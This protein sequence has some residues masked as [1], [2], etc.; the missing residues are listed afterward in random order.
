M[1][2]R[3]IA[4]LAALLVCL[5]VTACNHDDNEAPEPDPAPLV[6]SLPPATFSIGG[7][8]SGSS[9]PLT[10]QNSNGATLVVAASGAF[11][12]A[13]QVA[14]GSAYTVTVA[15]PPTS[16]TCTVA[17]GSGSALANVTNIAVT[18]TNN[19][20]TIGGTVT[21]LGAGKSVTL[22]A[23]TDGMSGDLTLSA[24]GTYT[25]P[26][27]F[28]NN[29]EFL[30][31]VLAQPLNQT[32]TVD[33]EEGTVSNASV[34]NLTLTC[35][36]NSASA[37]NWGDAAAL[38]TD[39]DPQ[40]FDTFRTPKVAFDAAGNALA[41]WEQ[42]REIGT[43]SEIWSSRYTGGAWAAPIMIPNQGAPTPGTPSG[44]TR[45][46]PQLAVAA[47]G[48]AVAVWVENVYSVAASFYSPDTGWSNPEHIFENMVTGD[49]GTI[50][51]RVAMDASG[52]VLVVWENDMVGVMHHIL[53][54]RYS[55]GVGWTGSLTLPR[56]VNDLQFVGREPE[57]AMLPNGSAVAMWLQGGG[58]GFNQSRMWSSRYDLATDSWS[59]PEEV[60][61]QDTASPFYGRII[62]GKKS[63]VMDSAGVASA[64]WA[65][66][67]GTRMHILFNR[68]N[69]NTWGTP[70]VVETYDEVELQS[71]AYD[72][73]A[74]V[75]GSGDIMAM[76]LQVDGD[77]GHYVA[78]RYVPGTGWGTQLNI[79]EY[80]HVGHVA[81]STDFDIVSN[82]AGDTVAVWTLVSG[83]GDENV[84]Y[85]VYLSA[86][87][88]YAAT[89]E[90]GTEEV[91]DRTARFPGDVE[92]DASK[93][94][95]AI[96]AQG[97]AI[98]VWVQEQSGTQDGV[99]VNR[100][101]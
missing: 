59:A 47:N 81:N 23:M 57:L 9:G 21:G 5:G 44:T 7:T 25:F 15:I 84:P 42:D 17:N 68:L 39:T 1:S 78:N 87:E 88:Y 34:T 69:G 86:N 58:G 77:E 29:A 13:T 4:N 99:R 11:T 14:S 52:N 74:S 24:N 60:D 36:D 64:V 79:G 55:P 37:R 72:V 62:V 2:N 12:F 46:K 45:R 40:D 89:G 50:D 54:N 67:D 61:S 75:D 92:G 19:G 65:Q 30:V 97:N 98:A 76:W 51:L 90:W 48:N 27:A 83:I 49:G 43:G 56:L 3:L 63:L 22:R 8:V 10:L 38:V 35:I 91:I 66:Y 26:L 94:A 70:A 18:C 32:C 41:I 6:P 28:V 80:V 20:Y 71:N 101:E 96:D 53:Y 33:P 73:R 95:V 82:A 16:Q 100:F 93:P 31:L 85:P